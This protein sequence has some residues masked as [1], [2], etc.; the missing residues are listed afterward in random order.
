MMKS[1]INKFTF[2]PKELKMACENEHWSHKARIVGFAVTMSSIAT[3]YQYYFDML[4]YRSNQFQSAALAGE[5]GFDFYDA[6]PKSMNYNSAK[7]GQEHLQDVLD[8]VSLKELKQIQMDWKTS[9]YEDTGVTIYKNPNGNPK[10]NKGFYTQQEKFYSE[11][12]DAWN[13]AYDEFY[14]KDPIA[15]DADK[16]SDWEEMHSDGVVWFDTAGCWK[17]KFIGQVNDF[18]VTADVS[19][20]P[21]LASD[22]TKTY[23]SN[24][25][26]DA[27]ASLNAPSDDGSAFGTMW[28]GWYAGANYATTS[29]NEDFNGDDAYNKLVDPKDSAGPF[30]NKWKTQTVTSNGKSVTVYSRETGSGSYRDNAWDTDLTVTGKIGWAKNDLQKDLNKAFI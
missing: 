27:N 11:Y 21:M 13:A 5:A 9:S 8:T 4:V 6:W 2:K 3:Y 22:P 12:S 20:N 23:T 15:I 26:T 7:W 19:T 14:A 1:M 16:Y 28:K 17:G 30:Q 18:S 25:A 24:P 10:D 29:P